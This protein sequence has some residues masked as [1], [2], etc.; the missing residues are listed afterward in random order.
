M[1]DLARRHLGSTIMAYEAVGEE[2]AAALTAALAE[3][4]AEFDRA[5][6]GTCKLECVYL[7]VIA[8]R[9]G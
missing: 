7:E 2:G 3:G 9:Y 8:T 5:D 1:A 4:V 6:D